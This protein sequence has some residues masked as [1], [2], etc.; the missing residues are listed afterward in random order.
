MSSRRGQTSSR[1]ELLWLQRQ[2]AGSRTERTGHG[3]Q[4]GRSRDGTVPRMGIHCRPQPHEQRLLGPVEIP[5]CE[6]RHTRA[7]LGIRRRTT[8]NSP[9]SSPSEHSERSV[10]RQ[11]VTWV[12]TRPWVRS[13]KS[14][15]GSRQETTL[16][17]GAGSATPVQPV[18]APE[19]GI[20]AKCI[21]TKSGPPSKG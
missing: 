13:G 20:G 18:E 21:S 17:S 12:S 19:S 8:K 2:P 4:S 1:Y 5:R 6:E 14:T 7:P 16:R 10:D 3:A 11:G 9:D 15:T